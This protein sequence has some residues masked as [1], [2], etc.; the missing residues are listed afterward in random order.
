VGTPVHDDDVVY[1]SRGYFSGPYMA[2]RL[3][4]P[5]TYPKAT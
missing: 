2:I 1:A 5:G 3:G 4:G